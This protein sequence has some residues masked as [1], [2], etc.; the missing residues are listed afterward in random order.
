MPSRRLLRVPRSARLPRAAVA[1]TAKSDDANLRRS[2]QALGDQTR[3]L[4]AELLLVLDQWPDDPG[5][6]G[7]RELESLV[8]VLVLAPGGGR[9]AAVNAAVRA[10]SAEV[11]AL[12][13]V[14]IQPSTL[15]LEELIRPFARDPQLACVGGAVEAIYADGPAPRWFRQIQAT[16]PELD[17]S[18][19]HRLPEGALEYAPPTTA[20]SLG[21]SAPSRSSV[22]W[23]REALVEQ[24]FEESLDVAGDAA[25][26]HAALRLLLTGGSIAHAPHALVH[27]PV[28]AAD[29]TE[30]A[31]EE[32]L[33][34]RGRCT[35]AAFEALGLP[36]HA[37]EVPSP[38]LAETWL[39][40]RP[41]F[42]RAERR[43]ARAHEEGLREGTTA[44][45]R[46]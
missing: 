17:P 10:T 22:A 1:L 8:D 41:T 29:L 43:L 42:G 27:A 3:P 35:A 15:W 25:D 24:P 9:A 6:E 14:G 31:A 13:E 21:G 5:A 28:G 34:R 20:R 23:R 46:S 39:R 38:G 40:A 36:V 19:L 4:G 2:L 45:T 18:P 12:T 33:R 16:R 32:T 11:L 30:A 26:L 7:R 44:T 37:Q